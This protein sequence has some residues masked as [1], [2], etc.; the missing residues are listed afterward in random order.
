MQ[1][2]FEKNKTVIIVL[3]IL[4]ITFFLYKTFFGAEATPDLQTSNGSVSA[5]SEDNRDL[6]SQLQTLGSI[7][8]SGEIFSSTRFRALEDNSVNIE[9]RDAEGRLNPFLPLTFGGETRLA[10]TTSSIT[11]DNSTQA[12]A[13]KTDT[14]VAT[15]TK[16]TTTLP[17]PKNAR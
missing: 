6:L 15:T 17:P 5:P 1:S 2:F 4:C 9:K 16:A 10:T 8:L 3:A 13:K 7:T 11:F 12:E 14:A